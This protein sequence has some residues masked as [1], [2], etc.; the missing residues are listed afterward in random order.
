[1]A[2]GLWFANRYVR[3]AHVGGREVTCEIAFSRTT[4]GSAGWEWA[5]WDSDPE[6]PIA[7]GRVADF[8]SAKLTVAAALKRLPEPQ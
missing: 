2:Q 1:M 8:K 7:H 5:I 3:V 4:D 6:A